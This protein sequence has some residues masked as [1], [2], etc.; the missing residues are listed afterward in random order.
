MME[1]LLLP[2]LRQRGIHTGLNGGRN[3]FLRVH[4]KVDTINVIS[5]YYIGDY[6]YPYPPNKITNEDNSAFSDHSRGFSDI[7][8]W[9]RDNVNLLVEAVYDSI[10]SLKPWVKFGISPFGIWKNN[11]PE[12]ISG[13][14][15]YHDKEIHN[16]LTMVTCTFDVN[17]LV[18]ITCL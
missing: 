4:I 6:F 8:N 5:F 18:A 7:E 10:N 12:G 3:L 15:S 11:V 2:P 13:T 1:C 16:I 17:V 9:R 14:S